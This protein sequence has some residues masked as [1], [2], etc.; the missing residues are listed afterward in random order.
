MTQKSKRSIF[1]HS[2]ST[3]CQAGSRRPTVLTVPLRLKT[4]GAPLTQGSNG[5]QESVF[6]ANWTQLSKS[7]SAPSIPSELKICGI[8]K[9]SGSR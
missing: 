1:S 2:K 8:D 9:P 6:L 7:S 3:D 4:N 5:T